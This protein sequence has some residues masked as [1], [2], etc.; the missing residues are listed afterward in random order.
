MLDPIVKSIE[1]GCSQE[2]AFRVFLDE[3]YT[4]WPVDRFSVS[5]M[6]GGAT[7]EVRVD[8]RAGG[9]IIEIGPDGAEHQWGE[10][11]TY[12]P[13]DAFSMD[14]NIAPPGYPTDEMSQVEVRFEALGPDRTR[15]ELTQTGWENF[16][17][18]ADDVRGGYVVGWGMIFEQ[19]YKAACEG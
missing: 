4:W 14:F 16:G 19:A 2:K 1:V 8:A 11:K 10:I 6:G 13:Y 7:K 18:K 15:V 5:V 12:D 9:K 17:D 3:M